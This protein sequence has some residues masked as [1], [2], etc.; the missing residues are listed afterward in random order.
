MTLQILQRQEQRIIIKYSHLLIT[1]PVV[2]AG[3]KDRC[4]K[5]NVTSNTIYWYH[6]TADS[7]K[8]RTKDHYISQELPHP[9]GKWKE[10]CLFRLIEPYKNLSSSCFSKFG[11]VN[12]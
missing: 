10:G 11:N 5:S 9:T 8:A 4:M 7:S 6:D 12:L 1:K 2:L 3:L